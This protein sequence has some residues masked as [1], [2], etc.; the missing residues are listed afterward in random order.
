MLF[1]SGVIALYQYYILNLESAF[2]SQMKIQSGDMAM[3]LGLFSFVIAFHLLDINKTKLAVLVIISGIF[4]ILASLL[5]FARGWI[6]FPLVLI[7]LFALYNS[8]FLKNFCHYFNYD[9]VIFQFT[10][11][12]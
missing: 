1:I 9:F 11:F 10:F 7:F 8:I 12:E 5:S 2:Y 3:S 6:A 4:G